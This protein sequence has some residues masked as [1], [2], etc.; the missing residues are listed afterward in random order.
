M[1]FENHWELTL[2]ADQC[3]N[4]AWVLWELIPFYSVLRPSRMLR[5]ITS[6]PPHT[7]DTAE[8]PRTLMENFSSC[9]NQSYPSWHNHWHSL[10]ERR[11]GLT[12]MFES[13]DLGSVLLFLFSAVEMQCWWCKKHASRKKKVKPLWISCH[14]L[15]RNDE[16]FMGRFKICSKFPFYL[17]NSHGGICGRGVFSI[18]VLGTYFL[19]SAIC[20][21]YV[22]SLTCL[23]L[24]STVEKGI[25]GHMQKKNK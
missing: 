1:Q 6:P 15:Q 7:I 8:F 17:F 21:V 2:F 25:L 5:S 20:A 11:L 10:I 9:C 18:N 4:P 12:I 23:S 3:L 22:C 13:A 24:L 19:W 16:Y 14:P